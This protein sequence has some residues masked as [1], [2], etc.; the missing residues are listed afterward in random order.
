MPKTVQSAVSIITCLKR[1]IIPHIRKHTVNIM[2]IS[3]QQ[4]LR[5]KK[6]IN[7]SCSNMSEIVIINMIL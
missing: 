2:I 7:K 5:T 6:I 4:Y 1:Y 3:S